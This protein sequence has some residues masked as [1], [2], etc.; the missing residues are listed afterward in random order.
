MSVSIDV[1][2]RVARLQA[3]VD[4]FE[5]GSIAFY[6]GAR[7]AHGTLTGLSLQ[8]QAN[9]PSPAATISGTTLT[10]NVPVEAL[11]GDAQPI[12]WARIFAAGGT[13]AV[14]DMDVSGLSG[15]GDIKL[16][17][18]NGTIGGFVEVTSFTIVG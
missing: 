9:L 6:A 15:S 18:V 1:V 4:G 8:A 10:L 14:M 5:G 2:E 3:L 13:R 11:R 17:N 16:S 12:E 7:P